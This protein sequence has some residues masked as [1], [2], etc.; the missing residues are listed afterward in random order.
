VVYERPVVSTVILP[1]E[2]LPAPVAFGFAIV[3]VADVG[4]WVIATRRI[5]RASAQATHRSAA[6]LR[7]VVLPPQPRP[8]RSSARLIHL[9]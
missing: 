5:T 1:E 6:P 4:T 7:A 2:N 3:L 8:P 9:A